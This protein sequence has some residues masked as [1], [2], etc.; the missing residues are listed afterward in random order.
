[1]SLTRPQIRLK[2]YKRGWGLGYA[3]TATAIAAQGIQDN[4]AFTDT[5]D[6]EGNKRGTFIYRPAA[7]TADQIRAAGDITGATLAHAG[8]AY[9]DPAGPLKDYE[10]VG[11][12]HPDELNDAIRRA[13][14]RVYFETW[15]PATV[16]TDGSFDGTILL[17]YDWAANATGTVAT[18]SATA[19]SGNAGYNSLVLTGAGSVHTSSFYPQPADRFVHGASNKSSALTTSAKYSLLDVTHGTVIGD[20]WSNAGLGFQHFYRTDSIPAGCYEIQAKL[21]TVGTG[22]T[23]WDY[24]ISHLSGRESGQ[25]G[26]PTWLTDVA[27][28]LGFGPADYGRTVA[29]H[30]YNASARRVLDWYQPLDF[31]PLIRPEETTPSLL[32]I[33]R[34]SGMEE[35]DF[36]FHGYRPYFDICDLTDETTATNAPEDLLMAAV[37]LEVAKTAM[38]K[39]ADPKWQGI[40]QAAALEFSA[41]MQSRPPAPPRFDPDVVIPGG[42]GGYGYSYTTGPWTGM[43]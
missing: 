36:W 34:P 9:S 42:R 35:R 14:R 27:R 15:A 31:E 12:M 4:V 10:I 11:I 38:G 17:P 7:A 20:T 28:L 6:A 26:V 13:Q 16:W 40:Y 37:S 32:Q 25:I 33:N 1:M 21:E 5:N 29:L 22:A 24:T 2:L 3:R 41:Q 23:T 8:Y 43:P 30:Q 19:A 18:K 39:V